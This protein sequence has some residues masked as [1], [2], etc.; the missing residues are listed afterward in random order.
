MISLGMK[1]KKKKNVLSVP[2]Q[3]FTNELQNSFLSLS[4][5]QSNRF[6]LKSVRVIKTCIKIDTI[7]SV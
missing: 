7:L 5:G 1:R 3:S 6:N 4:R 2:F